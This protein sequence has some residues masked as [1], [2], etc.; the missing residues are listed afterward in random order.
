MDNSRDINDLRPD[1][2]ANAKLWL[3]ECRAKGLDVEISNTV[4]D[5]E[6][7]AYL[8]TL[9]RTVKKKADGSPQG[10][11][12][13]A[14]ITTFHGAGLA[15]D[16]YSKSKGWSDHSFFEAC[17]VIAK[18]Y[19]FSWAGDWK[20]FVE[21]CH[22]QWDN[23]RKSNHTNAPQMPLYKEEEMTAEEIRK[24][25]REEAKARET[26]YRNVEDVPE[27]SKSTV[28]KLIEHGAISG[29]GK[30]IDLSYEQLRILVIND[31]MGLYGG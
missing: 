4:R 29:T 30:G 10:I 24:I 13:N 23:H 9:G 28:E 19:G 22:I 25:A 31:R 17:A 3:A 12:T 18:K 15:V 27:W 16:F 2:A 11:V 6:Y 14:K 1:V 26:I 7:Q 21:Y 5:N 20:S 8:Y